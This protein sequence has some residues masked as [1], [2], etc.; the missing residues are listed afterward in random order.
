[1]IL[2]EA[3]QRLLQFQLAYLGVLDKMKLTFSET[4]AHRYSQLLDMV[5]SEHD[6]LRKS[7]DA[8]GQAEQEKMM[9]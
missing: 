3:Q 5:A 4:N 2:K 8:S 9:Q 7:L 6:K 1:M